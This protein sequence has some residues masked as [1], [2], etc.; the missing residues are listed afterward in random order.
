M[1]LLSGPGSITTMILLMDEAD[2]WRDIVIIEG[3]LLAVM[4][5]ALAL[6]ALTATIERLM[7]R[8]GI[9]VV[10]RI[11]GMLLAALSVQFVIDGILDVFF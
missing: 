4:A 7:G 2:G 5:I 9:V 6:F 8:T 11:M 3:I 10:T 1:P